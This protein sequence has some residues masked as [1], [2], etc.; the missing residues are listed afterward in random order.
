ML[1][2]EDL[3]NIVY[4]LFRD[5]QSNEYKR[6]VITTTYSTI[7][8]NSGIT[9]CSLK[10]T[11]QSM[12]GFKDSDIDTAVAVLTNQ[13]IFGCVS[14]FEVGKIKNAVKPVHLRERKNGTP[15]WTECKDNSS[16]E[17]NVSEVLVRR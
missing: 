16:R 14:R 8:N 13:N 11:M 2:S 15:F 10:R 17:F 5:A 6:L 3:E 4:S 1:P 12:F 9:L 7:A